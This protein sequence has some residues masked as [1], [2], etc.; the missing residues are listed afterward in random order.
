MNPIKLMVNGIPGNMAVNVAEHAATNEKF[1]LI[2]YSLTGPEITQ[3]EYALNSLS[4]RLIRPEMRDQM[5]ADI[6]KNKGSFIIVD[7]THPSAVNNNAT[8]YCENSIPFVMGTTGGDRNFLTD[9]VNA[10]S[11]P[12]VIAPNM[13]KQ[14]VGFQAMMEYAANTFP[15][16]FD[17]Y[18]LEIKESHQKGK[19][20][21]S[22]TA[23]AMVQ[24]FNKLGVP[25][26]EDAIVKE[27]DP[28]IQKTVWGIPEEH[29]KGHG[30][31]TYNLVS[32]D[33]TV[34]FT[35]SHNINGRDVYARGTLDA[36]A[37]LFEKVE[38]GAKGKVFT[39]IDVLKGN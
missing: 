1:E 27:R 10:S 25:F 6:K 12:A 8:F 24:H 26:S 21:T 39:M 28:E 19:A 14:I 29:L 36:V 2:P 38:H 23:K 31:H 16:L 33:K 15:G 7:Y 37:Y 9:T 32:N 18:S 34:N 30:W 20:D 11:V 5:I 4:V 22:G 13:G 17:G 35:F 3:S